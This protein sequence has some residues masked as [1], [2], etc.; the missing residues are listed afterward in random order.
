MGRADKNVRI[1]VSFSLKWLWMPFPSRM[2]SSTPY[3]LAW[4]LICFSSFTSM[5][6]GS[7]PVSGF[8][9]PTHAMAS[10]IVSD[11]Y[12]ASPS[13]VSFLGL[14]LNW[15][16]PEISIGHFA[17]SGFDGEVCPKN[18]TT[19][20]LVFCVVIQFKF[21]SWDEEIRGCMLNL[22]WGSLVVVADIL[23][24]NSSFRSFSGYSLSMLSIRAH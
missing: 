23:L 6:R 12:I 5:D 3:F 20:D 10:Q 7:P 2:I 17:M 8:S 13:L 19:R 21:G 1:S 4:Y 16:V 14:R 24:V 11:M 9:G 22:V 15:S 18:I